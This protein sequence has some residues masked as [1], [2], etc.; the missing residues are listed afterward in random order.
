MKTIVNHEQVKL[1]QETEGSTYRVLLVLQNGGIV[2]HMPFPGDVRGLVAAM[3]LCTQVMAGK[4]WLSHYVQNG[5]GWT[6][7][8]TVQIESSQKRGAR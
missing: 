6:A 8:T 7:P 5:S 3:D 2:E 4:V 1:I